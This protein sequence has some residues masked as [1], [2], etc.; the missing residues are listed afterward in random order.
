MYFQSLRTVFAEVSAVT[1]DVAA[2]QHY[3]EVDQDE[4]SQLKQWGNL[5]SL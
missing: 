1:G 4:A 3:P 2:N 5:R